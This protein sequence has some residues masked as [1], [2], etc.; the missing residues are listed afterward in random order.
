MGVHYKFIEARNAYWMSCMAA[1]KQRNVN[2]TTA[3]STFVTDNIGCNRSASAFSNK[4]ISVEILC[5]VT[6][7][8]LTLQGRC[9]KLFKRHS[10]C[11]LTGDSMASR[12]VN[13]I[14]DLCWFRTDIGGQPQFPTDFVIPWPEKRA[15]SGWLFQT[16]ALFLFPQKKKHAASPQ[17]P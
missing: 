16:W 14:L 12:K 7:N 3:Y 4:T 6:V 15:L 17:E 11:W 1:S 10:I 13:P 8:W 5:I 9:R 2:F